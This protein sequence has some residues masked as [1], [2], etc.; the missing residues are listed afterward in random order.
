[1]LKTANNLPCWRNIY[2]DELDIVHSFEDLAGKHWKKQ[3]KWWFWIQS[4]KT[5]L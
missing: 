2:R 4:H 1:M 3:H 5:I